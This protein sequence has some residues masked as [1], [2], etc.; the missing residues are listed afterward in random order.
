MCTYLIET[1]SC[2]KLSSGVLRSV[3]FLIDAPPVD[4]E[5]PL[6]QRFIQKLRDEKLSRRAEGG[7]G[8][9]GPSGTDM[10]AGF[11]EDPAEGTPDWGPEERNEAEDSIGGRTAMRRFVDLVQSH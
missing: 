9:L 10:D 3:G 6:S 11:D 2:L 5:T 7:R 1:S 4:F 8:G